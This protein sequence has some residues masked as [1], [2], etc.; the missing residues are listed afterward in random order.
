MAV[1][2]LFW[3]DHAVGIGFPDSSALTTGDV[4]LLGLNTTAGVTSTSTGLFSSYTQASTGAG[5]TDTYVSS[6]SSLGT[7]GAMWSTVA[8]AGTWTFDSTA[9][10]T[11]V[12]DVSHSTGVDFAIG[13]VQTDGRTL[14]A[15]DLGDVDMTAGDL[16]ITWNASGIA[17][18][19]ST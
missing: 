9:N 11:W 1:G 18:V 8:A 16:T 7:W 5:T 13:Y 12:S 4:I 17:T 14:F 6:G 3:F 19:A 15:V 2:D 10:P